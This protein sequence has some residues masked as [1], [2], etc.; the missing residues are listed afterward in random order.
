M[1]GARRTRQWLAW[2]VVMTLVGQA[3]LPEAA[4]SLQSLVVVALRG[5]RPEEDREAG[6]P[7]LPQLQL[8]RV[9]AAADPALRRRWE[10][11]QRQL[12]SMPAPMPQ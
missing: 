10:R 5:C 3:L 8:R 1:R 4:L 11:L 7:A 2:L 6:C 9:L 12:A